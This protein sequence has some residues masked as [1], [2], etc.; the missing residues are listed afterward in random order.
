MAPSR[1]ETLLL[2][3]AGLAAAAAGFVVGPLL[4]GKGEGIQDLR[5]EGLVDLAGKRRHLTEWQGR[6][7]VC[8][9]WATWCTPCREE[10]PLLI[11]A[12]DRYG[13]GGV[14]IIGIAIDSATKVVEFKRSFRI[15]YP[16]LVAEATGLD[17]M[18]QLG[19]RSGGLPFTVFF[20]RR[21]E[22]VHRKLGPSSKSI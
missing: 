9:F 6:V 2:L 10:I 21:G 3:A 15:S 19:N 1:R 13:G 22:P 5:V 7:L 18:R 17:L 4:V 8:N 11:T 14:E 16:I 20:D 12:R